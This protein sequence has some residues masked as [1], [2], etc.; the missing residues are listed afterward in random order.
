MYEA[1]YHYLSRNADLS[2]DDFK[3]M[4]PYFEMRHFGKNVSL[5]ELGEQENYVNFVV[6]GLL[7]KFF[8]RGKYEI[9]TQLAK[10]SELISSAVS[11]L[12]GTPSRYIVETIE[13][14]SVI[15]ISREN[16]EI[17]Y[18]KGFQMERM[19]RL[20]ITDWL[21]KKEYWENDRISQTPKERFVRF[22]QENGELIR[23]V[24]QKYLASYLNIKPETFS[25]YK[26]LLSELP[27]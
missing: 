20:V 11:F 18:S 8:Y 17:I 13:P 1:L 24:P 22:I 10:E 9:V 14:A 15:S 2:R 25:R 6:E 3:V 4:A 7:R 19:G 27:L 5:V 26:H 23:R 12:S 16:M 21:L